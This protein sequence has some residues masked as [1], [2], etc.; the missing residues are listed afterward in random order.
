M[1]TPLTHII[2]NTEGL[3]IGDLSYYFRILFTKAKNNLN[4]YHNIR[5]LLH[6]LW[7]C[8][9]GAKYHELDT[10]IFRNLLIAAMFHD[11]DHSGAAN[12]RDDLEIQRSIR[13]LRQYILSEDEPCFDKI[14]SYI[15][16]TEYP[17]VVPTD[18]LT[19]PMRILRDADISQGLS[20]AWLQQIIFG[21]SQEL[22]VDPLEMLKQQSGFLG[23][24]VF[25]SEWG[26]K[27]FYPL[28]EVRI[29]EAADYISFVS[30]DESVTASE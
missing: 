14:S 5:H 11:F 23:K 3:Y 15:E 27:K 7:E 24:A 19:L 4:P 10:R 18:K 22:D 13:A 30:S 25:F 9:D 16:A 29:S 28:V 21:L 26:Q 6:V 20:V 17:Y 8:Y 2:K 1:P 12:G